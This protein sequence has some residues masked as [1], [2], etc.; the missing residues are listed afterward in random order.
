MRRWPGARRASR[1]RR[2]RGARPTCSLSWR[3]GRPGGGTSAGRAVR[4]R[5]RWCRPR[6]VRPRVVATVAGHERGGRVPK[7][8]PVGRGCQR[9]AREPP[10]PAAPRRPVGELSRPRSW[11]RRVAGG[12]ASQG[13][14]RHRRGS[15]RRSRPRPSGRR[16]S[17]RRA[18]SAPSCRCRSSPRWS[19]YPPLKS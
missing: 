1:R 9:G 6:P 8:P 3:G 18:R 11:S 17:L 12:C 13:R 7:D 16:A 14:C 5:A 2:S 4:P 10:D 15:G 19:S